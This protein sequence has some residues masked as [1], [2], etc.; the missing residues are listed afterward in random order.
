L[1]VTIAARY[2]DKAFLWQFFREEVEHMRGAT[3][4]EDWIE[5]G[6]Q[7]GTVLGKKAESQ[8]ILTRILARRFGRLPVRL[9]ER[10]EPLTVGQLEAL[11]DVALEAENLGMFEQELAARAVPEAA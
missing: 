2:F 10:L 11:I 3:F 8:A 4:I 9:A 5:E 1:A 6:I 7:Q